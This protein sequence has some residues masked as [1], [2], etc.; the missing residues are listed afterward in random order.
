MIELR[1]PQESKFADEVEQ[2]LRDLVVA[3]RVVE[4]DN[5]AV[6]ITD[7]S[8]AAEG[9]E[10]VTTFM[11]ELDAELRLGRQFQSDACY[12]D[13]NNPGYCL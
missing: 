3:F 12:L 5:G 11:D 9:Q 6:E 8:Q 1:R 7:G 13:P 10:A 2:R 4:G